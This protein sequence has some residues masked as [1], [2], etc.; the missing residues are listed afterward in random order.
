MT[1]ESPAPSPGPP[2][3]PRP[4]P[5]TAFFGTLAMPG[6]GHVL[7]GRVRRGLLWF[8]LYAAGLML[9]ASA[10]LLRGPVPVLFC[11]LALCLGTLFGTLADS[12]FAGWR[13]A[14]QWG[15]WWSRGLV[16][17]AAMFPGSGAMY[18]TIDVRKAT[19]FESFKI[20]TN[21]MMP[22]L[23]GESVWGKCTECG[24][25]TPLAPRES[26]RLGRHEGDSPLDWVC[27]ICSHCGAMLDDRAY[28]GVSS[29]TRGP[30]RLLVGK[31]LTPR[32]W[33]II[34]FRYPEEPSVIYVK[35]LVGLP[36]ERVEL[37]DGEVTIDGQFVSKP[38]HLRYLNYLNLEFPNMPQWGQTGHPVTLGPDEYYVLGDFSARSKDSRLWERGAPGHPPYAVP[39]DH[40]VGVATEIYW[41]PERW[42]V[43][44]RAEA[45]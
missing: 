4:M 31:R 38:E 22:A 14:W 32:R 33:D 45:E 16:V 36:G 17:A 44:E 18:K 28:L 2:L 42:R 21:A 13:P 6:L 3:K 9:A 37:R 43:F 35:R 19:L 27:G 26:H 23:I 11:G 12:L 34:A 8:G 29:A 10:V 7:V 5:L 20:S 39:A 15:E 25:K 40:V 1:I 41:P 30:D 24:E